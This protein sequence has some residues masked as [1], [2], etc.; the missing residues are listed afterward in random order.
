MDVLESLFRW[1][2][3]AAGIMWIGHLYFFNFVNAP[4]QAVLEG[5][6]KPKVNPELL[7]RA[8]Y[9]FRWGALWTWVT[10]VL[11]LLLVFYHASANPVSYTHLR[12]HETPEQ[13]VCRLL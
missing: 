5:P 9:W 3:I 12:A 4:F 10:G 1:I 13:L 11:M 7:P 6:L 8:L 2:H